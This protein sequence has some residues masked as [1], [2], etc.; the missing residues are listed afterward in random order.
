M[1]VFAVALTVCSELWSKHEEVVF[2]DQ[3]FHRKF[4]NGVMQAYQ[5]IS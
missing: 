3:E 5:G 1:V 4:E 2:W